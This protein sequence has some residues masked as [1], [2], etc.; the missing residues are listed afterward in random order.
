MRHRC[1]NNEDE[2]GYVGPSVGH[3][4]GEVGKEKVIG[5]EF[6]SDKSPTY[7]VDALPDGCL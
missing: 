7:I 1:S 4:R 6:L 3:F 5:R 2:Y